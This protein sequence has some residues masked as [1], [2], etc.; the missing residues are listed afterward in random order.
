M[1]DIEKKLM[2][3]LVPILGL[4]SVNDIRPESALVR[5]L[6]AESIDFVEILYMI[7]NEFGVK[8]KISEITMN[9]YGADGFPEDGR[10]TPALAEKL[11]E[12][13]GSDQF[14]EGQTT[15]DIFQIFTV[16]NL[17]KVILKKT[18]E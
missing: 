18:G 9:D 2:E 5:D 8:I 3:K 16:R 4:D 11:N 12:D 1:Q 14:K 17:A 13:F 6:G 15:A 10:L 7:E